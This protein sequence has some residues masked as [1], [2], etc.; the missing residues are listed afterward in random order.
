M[1]EWTYEKED[2][3]TVAPYEALYKFHK[4]P[5][6]HAA[7]MAQLAAYADEKKFKGFKL[8]YKKYVESL[9]A[10]DGTIYIDNVISFTGQPLELNA[11]DWEAGDDGI[12][13]KKR[14]QR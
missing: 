10:Q 3:L 12:Y 5:F 4:E 8:M 6:I 14:I 2:F 1:S 9:K 7:K 13:K 11:G